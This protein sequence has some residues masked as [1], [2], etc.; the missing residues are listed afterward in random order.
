ME[1]NGDCPLRFP[2]KPFQGAPTP[3]TGFETY[4]QTFG[5]VKTDEQALKTLAVELARPIEFQETFSSSCP[6]S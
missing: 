5:R 3:E 6:S 1:R 2:P 4:V